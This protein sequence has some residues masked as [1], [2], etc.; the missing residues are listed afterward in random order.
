MTATAT[1]TVRES[2]ISNLNMKNPEIFIGSFN[3][4]NISLSVRHKELVGDGS[5]AA[6]MTNIAKTIQNNEGKKGI[7]FCRLRATCDELCH[8]LCGLDIDAA[9]Y[10][11]GHDSM[12]RERVQ[13][14]FKNYDTPQVIVATVAFGLGIDI[15]N[16]RFV[17]HYDCPPSLEA[18]Y[19]EIGRAG[20]DG[21]PAFHVLYCSDNELRKAAKMEKAT[22]AGSVEHVAELIQSAQ[23]RRKTILRYFGE[24]RGSC[25]SNDEETCDYCTSPAHILRNLAML[26]Q[27]LLIEA[28]GKE[29]SLVGHSLNG[30]HT[31]PSNISKDDDCLASNPG[32]F[33]NRIHVSASLH[34]FV[35]PEGNKKRGLEEP[36]FCPAARISRDKVFGCTDS[37]WPPADVLKP[38]KKCQRKFFPPRKVDKES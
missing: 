3:R 26:E 24:Q 25:N 20:R 35:S 22:R 15:S 17:I 14:D 38:V 8:Y 6:V 16:I 9:S 33:N 34:R 23:C 2:I 12:R 27:K 5:Q 31:K 13:Y 4:P 30:S 32:I 37:P 11:A 19:Q 10:H 21:L 18:L 29:N 36:K 1:K 28:D 7:I